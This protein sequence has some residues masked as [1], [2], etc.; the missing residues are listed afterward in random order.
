MGPVGHVVVV[1][2]LVLRRLRR[3][4]GL[5]GLGRVV[6]GA[7]RLGRH[8]VGVLGGHRRGRAVRHQR[9]AAHGRAARRRAAGP[10]CARLSDTQSLFCHHN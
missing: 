10:A 4:R 6:V 8:V 3:R 2:L 5:V 1:V 9:G 7:E